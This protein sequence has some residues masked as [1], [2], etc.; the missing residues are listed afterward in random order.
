MKRIWLRSSYEGMKNETR[1]KKKFKNPGLKVFGIEGG[2]L[3][4]GGLAVCHV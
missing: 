3:S 2:R 1:H 4:L